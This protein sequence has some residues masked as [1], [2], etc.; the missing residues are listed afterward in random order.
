MSKP[1]IIFVPGAWHN[2]TVWA[3]C[4]TRLISLGYPVLAVHLPST[5]NPPQDSFDPDVAIIRKAITD[6]SETGDVVLAMHSYGGMPGTQAAKGM[7]K[8]DGGK[9]RLVRLVYI[10]SF[11]T[12][13]G[14][15]LHDELAHWVR[16][17]VCHELLSILQAGL[18]AADRTHRVIFLLQRSRSIFSI[19]ISNPKSRNIG[20]GSWGS[21]L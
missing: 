12:R 8:D 2:P 17:N 18:R 20:S 16:A 19:T 21:R 3:H 4:T 13:K 9:G 14:T 10:A 11:A 6:A 7:G 1:T 15:N 5:R